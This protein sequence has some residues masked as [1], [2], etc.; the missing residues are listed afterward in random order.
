MA[1]IDIF[2]GVKK[3]AGKIYEG[4][5]GPNPVLIIES[6]APGGYRPC[7][8]VTIYFEKPDELI[9]FCKTHNIPLEDTRNEKQ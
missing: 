3:I 2:Y 6:A 9:N 5:D 4:E 1:Y 7:D 8:K